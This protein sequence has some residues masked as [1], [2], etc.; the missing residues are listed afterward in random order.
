M[1][2][3]IGETRHEVA[4]AVPVDALNPFYKDVKTHED[5]PPLLVAQIQHFF[6]HYKDLEPGKRA[7]VGEWAPLDKAH[8]RI[9]LAIARKK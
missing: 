4:V 1:G 6:E 8:E 5:L 2:A 3:A 9:M 7:S